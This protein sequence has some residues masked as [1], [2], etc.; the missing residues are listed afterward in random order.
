MPLSRILV[1][2]NQSMSDQPN[3]VVVLVDGVRRDALGFTG[4][5]NVRTPNLDATA[6]IG[7]WHLYGHFGVTGT[8]TRMQAALTSIPQRFRRLAATHWSK[9]I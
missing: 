1:G 6:F 3:I 7:K 4:D 9:T 2:A 8:H 5:A